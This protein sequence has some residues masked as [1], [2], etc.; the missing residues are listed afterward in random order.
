MGDAIL[1]SYLL[2]IVDSTPSS[3]N[4]TSLWVLSYRNSWIR[5]PVYKF[6]FLITYNSFLLDFY[7]YVIN[8]RFQINTKP[9]V[10]RHLRL[11]IWNSATIPK[12]NMQFDVAWCCNLHNNRICFNLRF[13][14]IGFTRLT[15]ASSL[16]ASH[17]TGIS[18]ETQLFFV[19]KLVG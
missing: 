18:I 19:K 10:R 3:K 16:R 1:I 5:L 2:Y 11:L 14:S 7:E 13:E 9:R 15:L 8:L 12:N 17:V 4:A 6:F